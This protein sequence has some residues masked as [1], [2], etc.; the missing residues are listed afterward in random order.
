[1]AADLDDGQLY[2]KGKGKAE[3]REAT[4]VTPLLEAGS[5]QDSYSGRD[6]ELGLENSPVA[7]RKLWKKLA[8]VF[9]IT[10][11][12]SFLLFL[13]F[14]LLAY[15]Y[16]NQLA[17]VSPDDVLAEGLVFQGPD[18]VDVINATD[19][20]LWI[21][22][23]TRVG[24]NAG[25]IIGLNTNA[26]DGAL[27][28]LWKSFGRLGIRILG[29]V[30]ANIATIYLYSDKALLA[31]ISPQPL[32]LPITIYPPHDSSWL[33]PVSIPVFVLPTDNSS[34]IFQF[35]E[36]SWRHGAA[37]LQASIPSVAISGGGPSGKGWRGLFTANF[38]NFETHLSLP[39]EYV[40]H[41]FILILNSRFPSPSYTRLAGAKRGRPLAFIFSACY[42]R[43]IRY[44]FY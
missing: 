42:C 12:L 43:I 29:T 3:P 6:D 22:L 8:F 31:T 21:K 20:G 36:D 37:S 34:D 19:G 18:K 24:V 44:L 27:Q 1:M 4:E 28:N 30:T 25:S 38:D 9:V 2:A 23:D 33:T 15:S 14:G 41:C 7:R 13:V 10:L 11:S 35:V 16:A 26:S 32:Q 40:V 39:S 17:Y 5:S